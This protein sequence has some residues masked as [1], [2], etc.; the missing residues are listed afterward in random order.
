MRLSHLSTRNISFQLRLLHATPTPI[1]QARDLQIPEASWN[2]FQQLPS[3]N[4]ILFPD[5]KTRPDV[6][7]NIVSSERNIPF[8]AGASED[9]GWK[10]LKSRS[11]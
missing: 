5:M 9:P 1:T 10:L 3:P 6:E 8:R 7:I 11:E 4:L 2:C